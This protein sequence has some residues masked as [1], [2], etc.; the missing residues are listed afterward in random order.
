VA[1]RLDQ[2]DEAVIVCYPDGPPTAPVWVLHVTDQPVHV[3]AVQ[4]AL[5]VFKEADAEYNDYPR[6]AREW[7]VAR[8]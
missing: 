2:F 8:A 5:L 7:K 4:M 6:P 3:T 1:R